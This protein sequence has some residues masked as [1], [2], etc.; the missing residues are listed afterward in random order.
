MKTKRIFFA[1][2]LLLG[3]SLSSQAQTMQ[4]S[5]AAAEYSV[6]AELFIHGSRS[7]GNAAGNLVVVEFVG[8]HHAACERYVDLRAFACPLLLVQ[9]KHDMPEGVDAS[10]E[11]GNADAEFHGRPVGISGFVHGS[12]ERLGDYVV[13]GLLGIG[14]ALAEERDGAV[15][16]IRLYRLEAFIVY[17]E[18]FAYTGSVAF[19]EDVGFLYHVEQHFPVGFILEVEDKGLF[20]SV[21]PEVVEARCADEG[22]KSSA[23][24]AEHG[25]FDMHHARSA[26]REKHGAGRARGVVCE[27][28][29]LYSFKRVVVIHV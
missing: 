10:E 21:C 24:I 22:S 17:S 15:Y 1:A 23:V 5:S 14:P 16:D 6:G 27:I 19:E 11:I 20:P 26:L 7:F 4:A 12:R 2:L 28:Q 3:A 9:G 29:Y 8:P 13:A 25:F 18:A